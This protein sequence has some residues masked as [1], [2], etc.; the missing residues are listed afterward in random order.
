[1]TS[2]GDSLRM[3][4]GVE[5]DEANPEYATRVFSGGIMIG[6]ALFLLVLTWD[7]SSY[8]DLSLW[9]FVT[10]TFV[11]NVLQWEAVVKYFNL[12]LLAVTV[13]V[14]VALLLGFEISAIGL[15]RLVPVCIASTSF[16]I[17]DF[18]RCRIRHNRYRERTPSAG[19]VP[20]DVNPK[21]YGTPFHSVQSDRN[22]LV[23]HMNGGVD[24]SYHEPSQGS[25]EM[26]LSSVESG[27]LPSSLDS[28]T[29]GFFWPERRAR[30]SAPSN[31]AG[32]KGPI[33]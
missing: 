17:G 15:L 23:I 1:M 31:E 29:R 6:A 32:E 9:I 27:S 14:L 19:P 18:S 5:A 33:V 11:Y 10:S 24:N 16:L 20:S 2:T 4:G 7:N 8:R 25:S 3:A 21:L 12:A 30:G 13:F 22:E 28:N 26:S